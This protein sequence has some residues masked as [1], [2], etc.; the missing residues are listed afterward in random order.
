MLASPAGNPIKTVE[1]LEVD[2]YSPQQHQVKMVKE[3]SKFKSEVTNHGQLS[4]FERREQENKR[5]TINKETTTNNKSQSVN[6]RNEYIN[7]AM[8]AGNDVF[9]LLSY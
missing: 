9:A 2:N 5:Y 4:Q 1:N 8:T 7:P 3:I 6:T